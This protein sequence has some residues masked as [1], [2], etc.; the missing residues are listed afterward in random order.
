MSAQKGTAGATLLRTPEQ[1]QLQMFP[2]R[3]HLMEVMKNKWKKIAGFKQTKDSG[4][5]FQLYFTQMR[6]MWLTNVRARKLTAPSAVCIY[7][8]APAAARC[9]RV[10]L[11]SSRC[12]S[13]A[14]KMGCQERAPAHSF[15]DF[16]NKT[17]RQTDISDGSLWWIF[18]NFKINC[19]ILNLLSFTL[20]RYLPVAP[21][22]CIKSWPAQR[23]VKS[24]RH[25][26]SYFRRPRLQ[27]SSSMKVA[28]WKNVNCKL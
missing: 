14:Q 24:R 1:A 28:L 15:W 20:H 2:A 3:V 25:C 9:S 17:S 27:S 18:S 22:R 8:A 11:D 19:Q 13:T 4:V 7:G 26:C 21:K 12:A 16:Q 6:S 23:I 5:R 10:R